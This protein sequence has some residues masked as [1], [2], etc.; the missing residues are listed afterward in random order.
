MIKVDLITGFLGSGKTTFIRKYAQHFINQ[1]K[2]IGIL[3]NDYGAVNVDMMLLKDMRGDNLELEMV[4]GACDMD[5]HMRRFKTKLISMAMSG[6]DRVIIEPSGVFDVDEFFDV[7]NEEPLDKW[8][9]IGSVIAIVDS[10]LESNLSEISDYY[11]ASQIANAGVILLSRTQLS[12]KEEISATKEHILLAKDKT[13]LYRK[14]LMEIINEKPWDEFTDEDFDIIANSGYRMSSY[15]KL[16]N[17]DQTNYSTLYFLDTPMDK[18]LVTGYIEKLFKDKSYGDVFRIKG[19]FKEDDI[20]YQ[21]NATSKE[22]L[23]TPIPEGQQVLIVI[24][25]NLN[26]DK[27]NSLIKNGEHN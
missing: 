9:E 16:L 19:F 27:I 2:R 11:L 25:E 13:K 22:S 24:G 23:I 12:T 17:R 3:E 8:Y 15:I 1:G 26:E 4:A 10:R 6:Y 18:I 7:L 21:V 20:W 5:C 14:N